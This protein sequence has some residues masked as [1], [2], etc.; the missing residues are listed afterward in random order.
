M[1]CSI[2]PAGLNDLDELCPLFSGYREFYGQAIEPER[3]REYLATRLHNDDAVVLLARDDEQ[4]G[5]AIGFVLLY[6][7]YDS[8]YLKPVWV[9]HDLFVAPGARRGGTGKKLME[10]AHAFCR[11]SGAA[12]VDLATAVTNTVAQPLY[13]A[14]GYERDDEFY[15]YSLTL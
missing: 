10:A 12:R 3:E 6:P 15:Y 1:A 2:A 11:E 9:L 4:G 13:E 5:P 8:V 7:T 14:L